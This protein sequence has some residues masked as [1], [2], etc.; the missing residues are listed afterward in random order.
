[1]QILSV[2]A[3]H[4]EMLV[5]LPSI[6]ATI[7]G[8][9]VNVVREGGCAAEGVSARLRSDRRTTAA[10]ALSPFLPLTTIGSATAMVT[11]LS[12]RSGLPT[13]KARVRIARIAALASA[14]LSGCWPT[15]PNTF[16]FASTIQTAK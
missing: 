13:A 14:G 15:E 1:M 9:D 7:T 4:T 16:P 3:E 6:D 12:R 5:D 8:T 2:A 11:V 10:S